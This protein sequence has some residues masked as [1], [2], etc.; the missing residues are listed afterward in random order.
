MTQA[1]QQT[2]E[3]RCADGP[4]W[5]IRLQDRVQ[6]PYALVEMLQF[7]AQGHIG[8]TS[9]ISRSGQNDMH[10]VSEDPVFS[11]LFYTVNFLVTI[12]HRGADKSARPAKPA[13]PADAVSQ[14]EGA[15]L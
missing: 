6:G 11:R 9:L 2:A 14:P 15:R 3:A 1:M 13:V 5:D 4:A 10:P 7:I 8:S 12:K